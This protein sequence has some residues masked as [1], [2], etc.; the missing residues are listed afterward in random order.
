LHPELFELAAKILGDFLFL[1]CD[2]HDVGQI[3]GQLDD[4]ISIDLL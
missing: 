3:A 4:A 1:A 2:T